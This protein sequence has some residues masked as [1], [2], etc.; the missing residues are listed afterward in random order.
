MTMLRTDEI[1]RD[2][3]VN[4]SDID[5]FLANVPWAIR[6]TYHTVLKASPWAAIVGRDMPFDIPFLADWNKKGDY[7]QRQTDLNTDRENRTRK[8]WN[9]TVSDKVLLW[10][11][12]ILRKSESSYELDPWTI[13]S[14]HTNVTIRSQ[15]GTKSERLNI[16]RVTPYFEN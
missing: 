14:V 11:E 9:Y 5:T 1:A 15:C 7:R 16:W 2:D 10:K 3:S 8:D 4:A 12:G 13:T 6:F